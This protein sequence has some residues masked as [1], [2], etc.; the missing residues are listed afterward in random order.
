MAFEDKALTCRECGSEFI[1]TSGQQEFFQ[2]RGL[3]NEPR[4]CP[5][6]R[7]ARRRGTSPRGERQYHDI[8]CDSCGKDAKVPF[9][10]R[11]DRPTYC[12]ECFAKTKDRH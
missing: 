12:D 8:V 4:R 2:T 1:F 10:P 6:C 3:L 7:S 9:Q 11:G 5:A